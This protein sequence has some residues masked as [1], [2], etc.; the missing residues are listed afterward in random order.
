VPGRITVGPV[1]LPELVDRPQLV[2]RVAPNRVELLE[3]QRW[4]EPL[5]AGIARVVAARLAQLLPASRVAS[6]QEQA[7]YEAD[8]RVLLDVERLDA[9]AAGEVVLEAA[10][11]LRGAPGTASRSGRFQAREQAGTAYDEM[12]AAY[13]RLFGALA[14]Q[15]AR[16]LASAAPTAPPK[17]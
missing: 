17:P 13:G 7:G 5:K 3:M 9:S 8:C 1:T 10:W 2:L 6:R 4:A 11:T 14:S 16:E 12:V 15:L